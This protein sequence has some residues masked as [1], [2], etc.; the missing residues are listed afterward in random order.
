M[1][2]LV[3]SSNG[4][5]GAE[6]RLQVI[7]DAGRKQLFAGIAVNGASIFEGGIAFFPP[8]I[9]RLFDRAART[10]VGLGAVVESDSTILEEAFIDRTDFVLP[11]APHTRRPD[12]DHDRVVGVY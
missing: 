1:P 9:A 12:H 6:W 3:V 8:L 2:R 7:V 11:L 4:C 5:P 10:V